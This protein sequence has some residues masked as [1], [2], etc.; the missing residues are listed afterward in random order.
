MKASE[1]IIKNIASYLPERVLTNFDLE[2][3]VDTSDEW[4]MTRTGIKERRIASEG[5]FSSTMGIRAAQTLLEKERLNPEEID[6]II[7]CTMSPDYISP[8]TAALIQHGIGAKRAAAFDIQAACTG[9]V[10]GLSIAKAFITSGMYETI[11]LVAS[12][13]NSAFV[14]Y[15]DRNTCVLF[16]DGAG[17]ALITSKGPGL[18]IQDVVIGADGD[19]ADLISIQAGGSRNPASLQTVE[20]KQHFLTMKGPEVFKQAVLRMEESMLACLKRTQTEITDISWLIPHQAN[21]RIIDA[22]TKRID[23]PSDRVVIT[24]DK[25]ANT[26]ASTIPIALDRLL[27][28]NKLHVGD[29]LLITAV[30]AGLTWGSALLKVVE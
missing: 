9:F 30:G 13:K 22:L 15:T 14:D 27:L 10:Y 18:K 12:E 11:L 24:L 1:A 19:K 5:E 4:I 6:L 26:S 17:A 2:K 25:Y 3:M 21:L 23:I 8:S 20:K 7:V 29:N 28:E 16:G